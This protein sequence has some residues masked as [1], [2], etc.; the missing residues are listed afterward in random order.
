[1]HHGDERLVRHVHKIGSG[2]MS[3]QADTK[4][5]L[6]LQQSDAADRKEQRHVGEPERCVQAAARY[7]AEAPEAL[8]E[9]NA[10]AARQCAV[11][12]ERGR[13]SH[14]GAKSWCNNAVPT[15]ARPGSL[16][17]R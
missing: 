5:V 11:F 4:R 13:G 15:A 1:V 17:A 12:R 9:V 16:S 3:D 6:D 10:Q 8:P 2:D 14:E 7:A